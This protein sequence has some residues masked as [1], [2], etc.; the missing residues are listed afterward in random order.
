MS[1]F[2]ENNFNTKDYED[3]KLSE[4]TYT[5]I[6][7]EVK[8]KPTRSGNGVVVSIQYQVV[9]G[10]CKNRVV[11]GNFNVKHENAEA[12]RIGRSELAKFCDAIGVTCPKAP[13]DLCNKPV[14]MSLKYNGDFNKLKFSP[15]SP[16]APQ[17][18]ASSTTPP[19]KK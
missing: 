19:W 12:E 7:T 3:E 16:S 18:S 15:Y 11:F 9:D 17:S 2:A 10:P 13:S 8:E 1:F 5:V 4:G 6:A 14:M